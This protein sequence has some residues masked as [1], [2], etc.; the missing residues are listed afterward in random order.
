[1]NEAVEQSACKN[2]C[3][4]VKNKLDVLNLWISTSLITFIV[5]LFGITML[6]EIF[7]YI[8]YLEHTYWFETSNETYH[9]LLNT[10]CVLN[11]ILTCVFARIIW[12]SDKE[13]LQQKKVV[14]DD[15]DFGIASKDYIDEEGYNYRH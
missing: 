6:F 14:I 5:G 13:E 15:D 1:L 10:A 12:L 3:N 4:K 9:I 8:T 2:T 11:L 7:D